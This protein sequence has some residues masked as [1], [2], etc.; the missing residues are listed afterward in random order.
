MEIAE[1]KFPIELATM[2]QA[3]YSRGISSGLQDHPCNNLND[4]VEGPCSIST[5]VNFATPQHVDIRD[6]S[7]SVFG[8]LHLNKPVIPRYFL[9][10]N[11]KVS[12]NGRVYNGLAIKLVDG[13]LM[14]GDGR[15]IRHGTTTSKVKG[16]I[17]GYQFA[18]NGVSM[19]SNI[20]AVD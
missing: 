16:T 9:L 2:V 20:E 11:L 1:N 15:F 18:A 6:G 3:E 19:S 12:V 17:F 7:I 5:S 10:S 13:L 8:W 4:N 14:T